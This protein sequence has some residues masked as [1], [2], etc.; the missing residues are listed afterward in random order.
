VTGGAAALTAGAPLSET[1]AADGAEP[2]RGDAAPSAEL[3]ADGAADA[4][5]DDGADDADDAECAICLEVPDEPYLTSCAHM[6][7]RACIEGYLKAAAKAGNAPC[8]LCRADVSRDQLMPLPRRAG[9]ALAS[10]A[11]A[12][13]NGEPSRQEAAKIGALLRELCALRDCAAP[14]GA[15]ATAAV[16][17]SAPR[18]AP[19]NKVLV[20]TQFQPMVELVEAALRRAKVLCRRLDADAGRQATLAAFA[21]DGGFVVLLASLR[22]VCAGSLNLTAANHV[23]FLEP[24]WSLALEGTAL[25][26]VHRIGQK[27]DVHVCRLAVRGSIEARMLEAHERR[28]ARLGATGGSDSARDAV[29]DERDSDELCFLLG[30]GGAQTATVT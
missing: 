11:A 18:P 26:R 23:V 29:V 4:P 3:P 22:A 14:G 13:G 2:A 30:L 21:R 15:D 9:L 5:D 27:R 10:Y 17:P 16:E 19:P 6:F 8:P 20:L 28:C 12:S 1:I 24:A 25:E 7:C